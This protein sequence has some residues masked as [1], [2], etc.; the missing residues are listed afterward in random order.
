MSNPINAIPP[1]AAKTPPSPPPEATKSSPWWDEDGLSFGDLLDTLNPLQHLPVIST[2]YRK[3]TGDD[4]GYAAQ[5]TG[6]GLFGGLMGGV[7]GGVFTGMASAFANIWT[8][9]TTGKD[10]GENVLALFQGD[11]TT[12]MAQEKAGTDDAITGQEPAAPTVQEESPDWRGEYRPLAL[13]RYR[14][15]EGG[16]SKRFSTVG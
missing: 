7:I 15:R 5:L 10:I 16:E 13:E 11:D 12:R 1:A 14:P 3:F 2:L 9:E 4:I 8:R 6:D